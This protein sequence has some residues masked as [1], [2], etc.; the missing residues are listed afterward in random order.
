MNQRKTVGGEREK[1]SGGV[2]NNDRV[3]RECHFISNYA[4]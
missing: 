4:I 3:P 2:A 1:E